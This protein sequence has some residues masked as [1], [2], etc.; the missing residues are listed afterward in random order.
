MNFSN[1]G[2]PDGDGKKTLPTA[3]S[4]S[5]EPMLWTVEDV[6]LNLRIS[7]T[8][9]YRLC[10]RGELPWLKIGRGLRFVPAEVRAWAF[11]R[12]GS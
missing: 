9:I 12:R 11:A 10:S 2:S 3:V 1:R 4:L 5:N 7:E 6:S 8:T